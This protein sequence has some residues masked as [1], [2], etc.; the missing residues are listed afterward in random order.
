MAYQVRAANA[1][2]A[3]HKSVL[4]RHEAQR[5]SK[6]TAR[7]TWADPFL[8][9]KPGLQRNLEILVIGRFNSDCVRVPRATFLVSSLTKNII[10]VRIMLA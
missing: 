9:A 4:V 8:Y 10:Y 7:R 3:H 5:R 1:N 6:I 2:M